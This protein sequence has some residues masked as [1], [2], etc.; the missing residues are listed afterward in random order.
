M[1]QKLIQN[2]KTIQLVASVPSLV[3]V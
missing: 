1:F 2:I 3:D